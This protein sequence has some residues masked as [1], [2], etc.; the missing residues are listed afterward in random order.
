MDHEELLTALEDLLVQEFRTCQELLNLNRIQQRKDPEESSETL[1]DVNS[2]RKIL[3]EHLS[4]LEQQRRDLLTE[5]DPLEPLPGSPI[6]K[7]APVAIQERIDRLS[8][9]RAGVLVLISELRS[10]Q[11]DAPRI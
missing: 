3:L 1:Q 10:F 5:A 11:E 8:R 7:T 4:I 2:R 9:L 6:S